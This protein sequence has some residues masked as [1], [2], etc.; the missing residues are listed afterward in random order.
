MVAGRVGRRRGPAAPVEQLPR[1]VRVPVLRQ[2][3]QQ[4]AEVLFPDAVEELGRQGALEGR[5]GVGL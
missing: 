3:G 1:P 5:A 2:P 4:D